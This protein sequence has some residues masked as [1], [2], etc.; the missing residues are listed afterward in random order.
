MIALRRYLEILISSQEQR[1]R[2]RMPLKSFVLQVLSVGH[3]P[4]GCRE[5]GENPTQRGTFRRSRALLHS[6]MTILPQIRLAKARRS[7]E[8]MMPSDPGDLNS[9]KEFN[10]HIG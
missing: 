3:L 1:R 10:I 5:A 2:Y 6:V 7:C 4:P 9:L 8:D